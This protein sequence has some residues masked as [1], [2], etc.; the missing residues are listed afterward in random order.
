MVKALQSAIRKEGLRSA[1]EFGVEGK[2]AVRES[3]GKVVGNISEPEWKDG[4]EGLPATGQLYNGCSN[5]TKPLITC[6]NPCKPIDNP[7]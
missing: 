2:A 4:P 5:F 6:Q 3:T 1:P 7:E